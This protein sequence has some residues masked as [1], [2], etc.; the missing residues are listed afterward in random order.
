MKTKKTI[1]A[2]VIIFSTLTAVAQGS[3]KVTLKAEIESADEKRDLQISV[4][5]LVTKNL[6]QRETV[7]NMYFCTLP[8]NGKYMFHFKKDGYPALRMTFDTQAPDEM[9]YSLNIKL[10]I[11]NSKN[12]IEP[13]LSQSLGRISFNTVSGNFSLDQEGSGAAGL[14]AMTHSA[15]APL[16][17]KF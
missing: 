17:A 5:D 10:N 3:G 16:I 6:V 12:N 8:L 9:A 7:S 11:D 1:L 2:L 15:S 4:I 13:G 14:L